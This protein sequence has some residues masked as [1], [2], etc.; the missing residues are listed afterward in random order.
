MYVV[1]FYSFKG[2]VGRTMA[3]VNT[4][5]HL[6]QNGRRVLLVDFDLE[7]PG[8]DTFPLLRPKSHTPGIVEFVQSY[9]KENRAPDVHEYVSETND[10]PNLF[11]MPSGTWGTD[12]LSSFS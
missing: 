4:A 8:L 7:A 6:A 5:V 12:Y 1:T 10:I 3:L 9:I 2:G 11:V